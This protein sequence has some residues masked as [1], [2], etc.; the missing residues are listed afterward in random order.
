MSSPVM[1]GASAMA[2]IASAMWLNPW[3]SWQGPHGFNYTAGDLMDLI[4]WLGRGAHGFNCMAGELMDLITWL[5][6]GPHGFNCMAGAF[7]DLITWLVHLMLCRVGYSASITFSLLLQSQSVMLAKCYSFIPLT[8]PATHSTKTFWLREL[9]SWV[10]KF[11]CK[12]SF[13]SG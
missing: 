13:C 9:H 10:L 11:K 2:S 12:I 7:M 5:G 3:G 4:A 1:A 8:Q 6:R